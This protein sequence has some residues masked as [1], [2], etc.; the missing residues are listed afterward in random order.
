MSKL[1]DQVIGVI[2]EVFPDILVKTEVCVY[3]NNQRLFLDI[4]LPQLGIAIEVHGRQH[5]V[6]VEHFHGDDAGFRQYRKRD[7]IKEEWALVNGY[8]LV[9]LREKDLPVTADSLLEII[10]ESGNN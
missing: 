3:H 2:R 7:R 4:Y 9:V 10:N 8:T 1:C 6:F 5:D